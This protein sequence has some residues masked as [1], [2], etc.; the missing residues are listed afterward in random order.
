MIDYN[1]APSFILSMEPSYKLADTASCDLYSTEFSLYEELIKEVYGQVNQVWKQISGYNWVSRT[2]A[3]DGVIVNTYEK[4][5]SLKEVVI[6]YTLNDVTYQN[7]TVGA[8]SA[9]VLE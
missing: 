5:G 3:E 8:E 6:N 1:I 2:V 7:V 9:L 4:N